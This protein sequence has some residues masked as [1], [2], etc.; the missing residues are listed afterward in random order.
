M[1]KINAKLKQGVVFYIFIPAQL[2]YIRSSDKIDLPQNIKR[3]YNA[4]AKNN[5]LGKTE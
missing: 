5:K 2:Y 1:Y 3:N 4:N